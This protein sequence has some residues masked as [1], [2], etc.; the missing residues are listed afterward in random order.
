M[1]ALDA[2]FRVL[3]EFFSFVK[4]KNSEKRKRLEKK[5]IRKKENA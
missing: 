1:F 5:K 2:D 4:E 3:I